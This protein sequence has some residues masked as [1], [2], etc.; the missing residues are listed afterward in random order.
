MFS[1]DWKNKLHKQ[2]EALTAGNA[3]S[4]VWKFILH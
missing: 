3:G 1:N 4:G 2:G